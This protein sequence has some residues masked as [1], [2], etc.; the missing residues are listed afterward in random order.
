MARAEAG[1]IFRDSVERSAR[2]RDRVKASDNVKPMYEVGREVSGEQAAAAAAFP[3]EGRA[4]KRGGETERERESRSHRSRSLPPREAAVEDTR[5]T[6]TAARYISK[7]KDLLFSLLSLRRSTFAI[8]P[9]SIDRSSRVA[10]AV[11][12]RSRAR[13]YTAI[14]TNAFANVRARNCLR[15][16][17]GPA[18]LRRSPCGGRFAREK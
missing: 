10:S 15:T 1:G 7:V 8:I 4:R 6:T 12:V 11:A 5:H 18:K 9:L 3:L 2:E 17:F 16:V 13:A 14:M